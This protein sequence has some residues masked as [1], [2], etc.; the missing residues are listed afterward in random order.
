M[1]RTWVALLGGFIANALLIGATLAFLHA[2]GAPMGA[3]LRWQPPTLETM[4]PAPGEG[5]ALCDVGP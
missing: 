2:N 5:R 3:L 4:K 1:S